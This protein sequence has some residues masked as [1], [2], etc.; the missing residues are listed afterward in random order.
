MRYA[1][2]TQRVVVGLAEELHAAGSRKRLETVK[3]LRS[4][5]FELLQGRTGNGKS[6]LELALVL[7]DGFKQDFIHRQIAIRSYPSED[8]SVGVV[9]IIMR[10]LTY[11][12]KTIQTEPRRLMHLKIK[13]NTLLHIPLTKLIYILP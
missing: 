10:I 8:G 2:R 13:A 6:Q 7:L 9:V 11:I 3:H 12:E 5:P 4:I 1:R